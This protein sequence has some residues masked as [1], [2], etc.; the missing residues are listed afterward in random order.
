MA[1]EIT[2]SMADSQFESLQEAYAKDDELVEK[3]AVEAVAEVLYEDGDDIPEGKSV[4]DLKT[5]RV[6]AK[7]AVDEA[8]VKNRLMNIL[9]AKVRNYD[10]AKQAVSYST[11]EPS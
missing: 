3:V 8:Y 10:E 6:R 4:G 2:F 7:G 1:K 5:A 11:F 9:K